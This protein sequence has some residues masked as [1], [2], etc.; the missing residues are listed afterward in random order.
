MYIKAFIIKI[1]TTWYSNK[2]YYIIKSYYIKH[3]KIKSFTIR[4]HVQI[5]Y[6]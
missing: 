4:E 3:L 2:S 6:N 1:M 5:I